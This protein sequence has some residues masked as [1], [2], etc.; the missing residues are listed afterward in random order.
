M[1][2]VLLYY[3]FLRVGKYGEIFHSRGSAT[4]ELNISPYCPPSHALFIVI[5]DSLYAVY[6]EDTAPR[7]ERLKDVFS[8]QTTELYLLFY[9]SALQTFVNFNKFLQ[10]EDPLLPV[11]CEQMNSF[12]N[13][14][15]SKFVTVAKMKAANKNFLDLQYKGKEN[16]HPG[17]YIAIYF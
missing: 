10:R 13:K 1:K 4:L 17:T 8:K 16:Q 6:T 2:V 7:F 3:A 11:F 12:L 15:A 9:Q 14:L 5:N